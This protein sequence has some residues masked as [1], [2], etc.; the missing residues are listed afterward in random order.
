M[1]IAE[2]VKIVGWIDKI[3]VNIKK[4]MHKFTHNINARLSILWL[5]IP[6]SVVI[7]LA[8]CVTQKPEYEGI[9]NIQTEPVEGDAIPTRINTPSSAAAVSETAEPREGGTTAV[10]EQTGTVTNALEKTIRIKVSE[11]FP[12]HLQKVLNQITGVEIGEECEDG[13]IKSTLAYS[14][15]DIASMTYVVVVTFPTITDEIS[16]LDVKRA[17]NGEG[18]SAFDGKPLLL[19]PQT[20]AAWREVW[21]EARGKGIGIYEADRLLDLAWKEGISWALVPFDELEPRWKALRIDGISV[22]DDVP[23]YP[24]TLY[25]RFEGEEE[26]VAI[27]NENF[28][29]AGVI[30]PY[31]NRDRA[32][33]TTLI[34]TGTTALVRYTAER[35]DENGVLYPAEKVKDWLSGADFTHISN[36]APFYSKCPSAVPVRRESRFCSDPSYIE[37]LQEIGADIVELTGNHLMDWGSEAMIKTL[38]LYRK[39]GI[40]YYGGGYNQQDAMKALEIEHHGNRLVLLGCNAMGP[41]AVWATEITPGAA[42]CD[43]DAMGDMIEAYKQ[44]GYIVIVTLQHFEV[45]QVAPQSS[46][47]VDFKRLAAAGADIVSGSQAHCPQGMTFFGNSFIHYGLGNL[48]FDQMESMYGRSEFVDR[49]VFYDGRY[50]G[51]ELLTAIL[52]DYAQP[53]P[54]TEDERKRFLELIFEGSEWTP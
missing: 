8:G 13:W 54:M 19:S 50:L 4:T 49:H 36:E 11:G 23:S 24:L 20:Y 15:N 38:D 45:C 16:L 25:Y 43:F 27:L 21:G 44:K 17:W 28:Q 40:R 10:L 3:V 2:W 41:E 32:K 46:Q 6:L 51:V 34:L 47:R 35:M 39:E 29:N 33:M 1:I 53:R 42:Q 26:V 22:F 12:A 5:I 30:L 52:E 37:L 7:A 31:Q 48:F 9:K 18:V 14:D